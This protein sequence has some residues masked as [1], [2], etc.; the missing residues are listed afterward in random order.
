M[1]ETLPAPTGLRRQLHT[2]ARLTAFIGGPVFWLGTLLHPARDGWSI[3]NV[4]ERYG[5][6]HDIQAAGLALQIVCLA[7]ML[8]LGNQIG[9]RRDLGAWYAALVGTLLWFALII[10]DGSHNPVRA[11]YAPSMVHEP[12]D[13]DTPAALI[14]FPALLVFPLS[15][16]W[17]GWTLRKRLRLVGLLLGAGALAYTIGGLFIFT[18]GP[19]FGLIQIFEVAGATVYAVGYILLGR[20][21]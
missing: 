10:F 7:S 17:L 3:A 12:A 9:R 15:Y 13:L 18:A 11:E 14:V 6:T 16:L 8:A 5:L 2:T 19:K 4:G 1:T 21:A 20:R